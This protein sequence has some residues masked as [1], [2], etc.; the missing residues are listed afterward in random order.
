MYYAYYKAY[1]KIQ[2]DIYIYIYVYIVQTIFNNTLI[3]KKLIKSKKQKNTSRSQYNGCADELPIS[4]VGPV[5]G[6]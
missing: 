1:S 5:N 2:L 6:N 3:N 4:S